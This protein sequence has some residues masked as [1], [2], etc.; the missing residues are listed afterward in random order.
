MFKLQPVYVTVCT[1]QRA[2]LVP[3][4]CAAVAHAE[5]SRPPKRPSNEN[6]L[7]MHEILNSLGPETLPGVL[8][9][10]P[11]PLPPNSLGEDVED[12]RLAASS[13]CRKS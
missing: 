12:A 2:W 13:K 7:R 8:G 1:P 4:A 10:V 9:E 3:A 6:A 11:S 5:A